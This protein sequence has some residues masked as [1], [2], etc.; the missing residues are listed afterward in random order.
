MHIVYA[1]IQL[2]KLHKKEQL[3]GCKINELLLHYL[4]FRWKIFYIFHF[5]SIYFF[6]I[7]YIFVFLSFLCIKKYTFAALCWD[8]NYHTKINF[9]NCHV[10]LEKFFTVNQHVF[11]L[12]WNDRITCRLYTI[13]LHMKCLGQL[14]VV[15][16]CKCPMQ[17]K[18]TSRILCKGNDPNLGSDRE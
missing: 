14:V 11:R 8:I 16:L 12:G 18:S 9:I 5:W 10:Q 17:G 15:K 7:S 3:R 1:Y 13:V 6:N 2:F 4:T